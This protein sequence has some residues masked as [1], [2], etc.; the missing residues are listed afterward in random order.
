MA[1]TASVPLISY[2]RQKSAVNN[3]PAHLRSVLAT[4]AFWMERS[5]QR[6]RLGRLD[7]RLL[8]DIGITREQAFNESRKWFW[9]D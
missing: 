5:R 9:Q 6:R 2:S 4:L 1:T 7:E 3:L 8:Q